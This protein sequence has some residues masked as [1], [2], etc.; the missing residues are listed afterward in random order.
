MWTS[1]EVFDDFEKWEGIGDLVCI[2]YPGFGGKA[3]YEK[4]L[5]C[6]YPQGVI[7]S[8]I[9]VGNGRK[10]GIRIKLFCRYPDTIFAE[11]S[12]ILQRRLLREECPEKGG[13]I[14]IFMKNYGKSDNLCLTYRVDGGLMIKI[15][16]E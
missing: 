2:P 10:W 9:F 3:G 16:N 7:I 8:D 11:G 6:I 13:L 5:N 14:D 1:R 12:N 15:Y 4:Y